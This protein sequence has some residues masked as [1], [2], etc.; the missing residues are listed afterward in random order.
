MD[1]SAWVNQTP[2][3]RWEGRISERAIRLGRIQ[4][5]WVKREDDTKT[6]SC[7]Y[8]FNLS[9]L[10][11]DDSVF[12]SQ[13]Y[14]KTPCSLHGASTEVSV[15]HL[16]RLLGNTFPGELIIAYIVT[17]LQK[18][19]YKHLPLFHYLQLRKQNNC[20]P[21]RHGSVFS[22]NSENKAV[23]GKSWSHIQFSSYFQVKCIF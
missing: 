22:T 4:W 5:Q 14:I 1:H 3:E 21:K 9:S 12:L 20:Q 13:D 19:F 7:I 10:S 6:V 8:R 16:C 15:S 17:S 2:Q 23:K 18:R 11:R